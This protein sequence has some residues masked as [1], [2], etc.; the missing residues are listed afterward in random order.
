MAIWILSS[1]RTRLNTIVQII[2]I[3]MMNALEFFLAPELLL[4]GKF[5][6][7]FAFLLITVIYFNEFH[8]Q[9]K[10]ARNI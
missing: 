6:S 5:N 2:I 8:L 7:V 1:L 9:K 4:W 3:A 10:T